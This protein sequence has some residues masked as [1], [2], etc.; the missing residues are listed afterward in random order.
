MRISKVI[1]GFKKT[2][3]KSIIVLF[4]VLFCFI[5][6]SYYS[7]LQIQCI[8]NILTFWC[9]PVDYNAKC[10]TGYGHN[11]KLGTRRL[12]EILQRIDPIFPF[13]KMKFLPENIYSYL[14]ISLDRFKS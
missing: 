14:E 9:I 2:L 7:I 12:V 6:L 8:H 1:N 5:L 4:P 11:T 3:Q 13:Y 10:F